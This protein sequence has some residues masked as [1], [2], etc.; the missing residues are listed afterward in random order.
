MKPL[1]LAD[2]YQRR[3]GAAAAVDVA[4]LRVTG[5]RR[6]GLAGIVDAAR[7]RAEDGLA[8]GLDEPDAALLR[9]MVLGQDEQLSDD[10]RD[11]FKRSGLAHVL[12]V[13]GQNVM[14]LATLV[15]GVGALAALGLRSR[16][17]VALALVAFYVPLTGAGPSIQ[18]AGVM[19]APGWSPRWRAVRRIAGT[20]S[21]SPSR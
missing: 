13:S 3:R 21:G 5:E 6:G 11:D 1:G 15:L 16:L 18:R 8:R 20:R 7:R 10:V 14:L 19:G 12:A 4:R 9:G 2:A 17:L